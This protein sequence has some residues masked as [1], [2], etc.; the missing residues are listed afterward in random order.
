MPASPRDDRSPALVSAGPRVLK[1]GPNEIY[2]YPSGAAAFAYAGDTIEIAP[3]TYLDCAVWEAG[4]LTIIGKGDVI[5]ADTT[6]EREAIFVTR[7]NDITI[8]GIT[9]TGAKV[10]NNNGAGIRAE[11]RNL[12]VENSKFID[13]EEGI[14]TTSIEDC[15]I[16]IRNSY[17]A[18]NGNCLQDC[19]HGIYA[20]RIKELRIEGS[21][22]FNQKIGHH[23]KSRALRTELVGN[24]IHDGAEGTASYLVDIPNGGA[25][26]MRGNTLEKGPRTDNHDTAIRLG[27][28]G[29]TNVTPQILIENNRFT[30]SISGETVFV[31]NETATRAVLRANRLSGKVIP[32][33]GL[34]TTER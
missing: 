20:G 5:L 25:L 33:A 14:L 8:R 30:N 19:S 23:V 18:G 22:F 32:L 27:E 10:R 2:K 21:E 16:V 1:V 12:T 17:F 28:E 34:G 11:G 6:C 15:T 7:G 29:N 9:F 24:T 13:N 3:G 31:R 4:H 26:I